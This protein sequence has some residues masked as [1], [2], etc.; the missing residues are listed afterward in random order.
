MDVT[1]EEMNRIKEERG[2]SFKKLSEYTGVPVITLQK[3]FSGATL[4]PRKVTLDAIERVLSADQEIYQGKAYTYARDKSPEA[5][6]VKEAATSYGTAKKQGEYTLEDYYALPDEQRV[7]LIDG[8]FYDMSSPRT[9]H[10]DITSIIHFAFYDYIR[11]SGKNCKVFEAP[12]DVQLCCDNKTMVQPDVLVIC[13][14]DKIKGFGIYGAP[15]F[16]LEV[17][18]KS[19]RKKDMSV[20]L[21]KY[22]EAGVREFWMIDPY[23]EVLITYNFEDEDFVPCI[24]PLTGSVPVAISGGE[25]KIDLKPVAESVRELGSLE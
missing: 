8:V 1:R 3:V 2:Y 20:K 21:A 6:M 7:E 11:K 18:S 22:L 19:T 10:Q 16:V 14:R 13:D 24:Y 5:S 12:M 23:K 17:L 4:K 25:L 15:D 9:V